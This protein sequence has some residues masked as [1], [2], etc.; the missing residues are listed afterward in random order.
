MATQIIFFPW[1]FPGMNEVIAEA[2]R[3]GKNGAYLY[4]TFKAKWT[5]QTHLLIL[6]AGIQPVKKVFLYFQWREFNRRRD[7]DNIAGGGRKFILDGLVQ[8]GILENDGWRH[9]TGWKDDFLI[10][11]TG[12][13]GA[14][15]QITEV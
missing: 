10:V 12:K 7:P 8:A 4:S 15:V 5:D 13:N 2:K 14:Q 1:S 3:R 9:V 11:D 6:S